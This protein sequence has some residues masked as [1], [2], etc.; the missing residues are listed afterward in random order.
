VFI[1]INILSMNLLIDVLN[2]GTSSVLCYSC[3][4]IFSKLFE[5][6]TEIKNIRECTR[7]TLNDQTKKKFEEALKSKK[8]VYVEMNR[9]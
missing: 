5:N 1:K 8:M 2:I 4:S 6:K 9:K 7:Y 3:Y